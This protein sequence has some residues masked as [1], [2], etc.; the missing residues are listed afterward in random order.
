MRYPWSAPPPSTPFA[1]LLDSTSYATAAAV[2]SVTLAIIV[3][4]LATRKK[5]LSARPEVKSGGSWE[6]KSGGSL[7]GKVVTHPRLARGG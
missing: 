3:S 5:R 1:Q 4:I 6:G 7:E 2:I